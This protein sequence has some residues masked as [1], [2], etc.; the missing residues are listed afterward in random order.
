[1]PLMTA[2]Q[3]LNLAMDRHRA[4]QFA[5]A[6]TI[7]RQLHALHPDNVDII[8]LLGIVAGDTRRYPESIE[9]MKRS[10]AA[11]PQ[12]AR[13]RSNYGVIL[14]DCGELE[15]SASQL[16]TA[17]QLQ[18][19]NA[20]I[21]FNLGNTRSRQKEWEPAMDAYRQAL[22]LNPRYLKAWLNLGMALH[23]AN[24]PEEAIAMYQEARRVL[25]FEYSLAANLG[26]L[27]GAQCRLDEAIEAY[28]AA[29]E[30]APQSFVTLNNLAILLKDRGEIAESLNVLR[31]SLAVEANADVHSNLIFNL[32][33]DPDAAPS[34]IEEEKRLWNAHFAVP[35]RSARLPHVRDR[36]PER[37]L[38]VGYV[39]ADLR[40]HVVGRTLLPIFEAHDPTQVECVCYASGQTD[41]VSQ[42][43][44]AKAHLWRDMEHWSDDQLTEQ[45]RTDGIDILVDLSLHTAYHRLTVFARRP[46][47]VQ[48]SWLGYPGS[49]GVE[50]IDHWL[51]DRFLSPPD[52]DLPENAD[53]PIR[54][55]DAWC[56][57]PAPESS[58]E[59]TDLPSARTGQITFGCFNN[60]SKINE[61]VL[62]LWARILQGVPD[63]RLILLLKTGAHREKT[64][65]AIQ[66]HGIAAE[67]LVFHDYEPAS[68]ERS[69]SHFLQRYAQV[70]IAL[71]PF[72]YNGMTTTCDALWMGVP[73]IAL[74][75]TLGISRASFSLLANLG[76]PEYAVASEDE[77]CETAVA[78]AGD[79]DRLAHLRGTLRDR[80]MRSP[81]LDPARFARHLEA[82]YREMWGDWCRSQD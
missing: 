81:L 79:R 19:G 42:R 34:A 50:T 65:E 72:P 1:M 12:V 4:G 52:L 18:P 33:F 22:Q 31:Q 24:R 76:L 43:F 77:Y 3:A 66:R 41:A 55:P 27:L 14:L 82:A 75:G 78:L 8:H 67:R 44:Q 69:A 5:E 6:E 25:P 21:H 56:C 73:V 53:G 71:D 58:P 16:E 11:Q 64:L 38:R 46:A 68:L 10:I 47:P 40:N 20:D 7:Y 17:R 23:S 48:V 60:F 36:S 37:R 9:W 51:T 15:E 39:S 74:R 32:H 45:I 29:V 62:Q 57:Y 59:V 30:L 80:V 28:Q 61:R 63:S 70:D 54:L 26:N 35:L 49:T 13:Y 2:Q